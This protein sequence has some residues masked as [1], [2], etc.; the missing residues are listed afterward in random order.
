MDSHTLSTNIKR[1]IAELGYPQSGFAKA[2]LLQRDYDFLLSWLA[3][4]KHAEKAYLERE[5]IKRADPTLLVPGAK[6]VIA[7]LFPYYTP[8]DLSEKHFY[9]ISRYGYG[10]DYHKVL[11]EKLRIIV[12]FIKELTG[13]ENTVP[14]VDSAPVFEKAWAQR[15][16][17]GWAGKNT[18]LI[19]KLTGSFHFI[20]IIITDVKLEYDEAEKDGCGSCTLCM[21][22]CPA[23]ALTAPHEIDIRK[24]ISHLTM[25]Q[26][27]P[28]PE[29]QKEKFQNFI[30]GCD[31]CQNCCPWNHKLQPTTEASFF[32][33]EALKQMTQTDWD[34]LSEEKFKELF[35]ETA[36]ERVGYSLLKRNIA[37]IKPE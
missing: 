29:G 11:K 7:F 27:Y 12:E 20:G 1:K 9:K 17:L 15:C 25:E 24:C 13:S 22:A 32:P 5:P 33:S 21:E 31:I 23:G 19:N 37:Y 35:K 2:E 3:E 16:G 4:G 18:L 14:Y 6:S 10:R 36:I 28:L 26:K 30:Y 8:E 34:N